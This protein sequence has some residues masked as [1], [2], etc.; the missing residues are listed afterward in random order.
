MTGGCTI[1]RYPSEG[2]LLGSLADRVNMC[3]PIRHVFPRPQRGEESRHPCHA[4]PDRRRPRLGLHN[5]TTEADRLRMLSAGT[6]INPPG[7]VCKGMVGKCPGGLG[8]FTR[9]NQRAMMDRDAAMTV[10]CPQCSAWAGYPCFLAKPRKDGQTRR[11]SIHRGRYRAAMR[12][13]GSG[14]FRGIHKT[15]DGSE[16]RMRGTQGTRQGRT[17]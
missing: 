7:R 16:A 5:A 1:G 2:T 10:S 14:G 4:H 11:R 9:G 17:S 8:G 6:I 12:D 13:G 3:G 15:T